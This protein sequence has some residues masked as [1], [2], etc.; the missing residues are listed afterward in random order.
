MS[1]TRELIKRVTR[2]KH[3]GKVRDRWLKAHPECIATGS[4]KQCEVHHITPFS[5]RPEW[6]LA[7]GTGDFCQLKDPDGNYI[8]N[9]C[10]LSDAPNAPAHRFVGHLGDWQ[11][12]NDHVIEDAAMWRARI[13]GRKQ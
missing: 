8:V 7:D 5:D 6:E 10:T 11:C 3:W 4:R 12:N 1:R 9:L 13:E 2:S